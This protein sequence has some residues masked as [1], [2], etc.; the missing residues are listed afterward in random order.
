LEIKF[1]MGPKHANP[2]SLPRHFE[3]ACSSFQKCHL[4]P[5]YFAQISFGKRHFSPFSPT[6]K[7]HFF[8]AFRSA[9]KV[10]FSRKKI[11]EN[12]LDPSQ[13]AQHV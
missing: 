12:R 13:L 5:I 10:P 6:T 3:E 4:S 2:A 8:A 9:K 11:A 1:D 7:R